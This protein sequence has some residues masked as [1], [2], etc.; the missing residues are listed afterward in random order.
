MVSKRNPKQEARAAAEK[1]L[2]ATAKKKAA[3]EAK[4]A[5]QAKKAQQ[6]EAENAKKLADQVKPSSAAKTQPS[7]PQA[8]SKE[9]KQ[10]APTKAPPAAKA[11]PAPTKAPLAGKAAPAPTKTP[12]AAKA[13]PAP[14]KTSPAAKASAATRA[15]AAEEARSL[16]RTRGRTSTQAASTQAASAKAA[17]AKAT[18]RR[19]W[20]LRVAL[21]VVAL[22]VVVVGV[23]SWDRWLR[24]DDASDFQGTWFIDDSAKGVVIDGRAIKLTDDVK[25]SYQ[26]DPFAKTIAF[27]FGDKANTGRYR[28]SADRKQLVVT[29][30]SSFT[31]LSTLFE[32][33]ALNW[34][35]L[36]RAVQGEQ[37]VQPEAGNGITVFM[38]KPSDHALATPPP[39]ATPSNSTPDAPPSATPPDSTPDAPP[40]ANGPSF[41]EPVPTP[42]PD[43]STNGEAGADS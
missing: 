6:K 25:F 38:R 13:A 40:S 2:A 17:S 22:S 33:I 42:E 8:T 35:G 28:F 10:P 27:S 36:T 15:T 34:Q 31:A 21:A 43:Q 11:A 20:P 37:P 1:A 24:Y 41:K 29:E 18:K 7:A 5:A 26:I 3:A 30:G 32:D 14:A 16:Q 12:P 39:S 23:F 9:K 4:A 19:R